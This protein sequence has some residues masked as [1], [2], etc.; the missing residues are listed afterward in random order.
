M[1]VRDRLTRLEQELAEKKD[2]AARLGIQVD[3]PDTSQYDLGIQRCDH[4][5]EE[6]KAKIEE[7]QRARQE[8]EQ[9]I[10]ALQL[11]L[12]EVQRHLEESGS[13]DKLQQVAKILDRRAQEQNKLER[14]QKRVDDLKAKIKNEEA[15]LARTQAACQQMSDA[16]L[17]VGPRVESRLT[18]SRIKAKI[19]QLER[20]FEEERSR[21][22]HDVHVLER[23]EQE[24][25]ELYVK[26]KTSIQTVERRIRK[27]E[28]GEKNRELE[29]L[30]FRKHIAKQATQN[31]QWYMS[32]RRHTGTILFDHHQSQLELEVSTHPHLEGQAT[33]DT[34]A[35]SGGERSFTTLALVLALGDSMATPFRFFDEFDIFMDAVNRRLSL[36]LLMEFAASSE[37]QFVF[38]TPNDV[39]GIIQPDVRVHKLRPP[40]RGQRVLNF[41]QN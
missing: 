25:Q 21:V 6:L 14:M 31:F 9:R 35:L 22:R 41:G 29:W 2:D 7:R 13:D 23:R 5:V 4:E 3:I 16:A 40:E 8:V 26:A 36:N 18:T 20:K 32:K 24:A 27:I 34:K 15:L 33:S 19:D 12:Q 38:L 37:G 10:Q 28:E 30:R 39:T 1:K 11:D 17:Q